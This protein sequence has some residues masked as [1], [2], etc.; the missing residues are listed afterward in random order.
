MK[1]HLIL[2]YLEESY[3]RES[4]FIFYYTIPLFPSVIVVI[5]NEFKTQFSNKSVVSALNHLTMYYLSLFNFI[6]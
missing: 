5:Y 4:F 6:M 1:K 3:K 2:L